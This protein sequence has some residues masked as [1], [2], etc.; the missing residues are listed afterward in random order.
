MFLETL[1][2]YSAYQPT[3]DAKSVIHFGSQLISP[4]HK[5]MKG[6]DEC[7]EPDQSRRDLLAVV[8][9]GKAAPNLKLVRHAGASQ[10]LRT[11]LLKIEFA[12][13]TL[14]A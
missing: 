5:N 6:L 9:R 7:P 14:A 12:A 8:K 3:V 11:E 2:C 4:S 1:T 13:S 10:G